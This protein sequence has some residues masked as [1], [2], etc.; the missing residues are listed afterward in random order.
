MKTEQSEI[1][2]YGGAFN[3]PTLAHELILRACVDYAKTHG[4][5]VWLLPSGNRHDKT[6]TVS[7]RQRLAYV[8]AMIANV[9][10]DEVSVR[11]ETMELDQAGLAETSET[12][13]LLKEAHPGAR[14]RFVFGA[15]STMTMAS[16]RGGQELLNTLPMLIVPRP[17]YEVNPM[18]R[19]AV[20]LPIATPDVSST[21]VRRRL[22]AEESI[23][24]LVSPRVMALLG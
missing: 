19:Q 2:V 23:E 9:S 12:V 10:D 24:A 11:V 6:I 13:R 7:R 3:P 17:G 18:A 16:W 20:L 22:L 8:R 14:F 15:D 21:E 5:E 4:G 1:I